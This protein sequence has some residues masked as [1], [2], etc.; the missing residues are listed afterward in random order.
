MM[1]FPADALTPSCQSTRPTMP[2]RWWQ[3]RNG[4]K[5]SFF[6]LEKSPE[7]FAYALDSTRWLMKDWLDGWDSLQ[8]NN[9]MS[10]LGGLNP[11]H[12]QNFVETRFQVLPRFW[13]FQL[14]YFETKGVPLVFADFLLLRFLLDINEKSIVPMSE[15]CDRR[16]GRSFQATLRPFQFF[17]MT[18]P[19]KNIWVYLCVTPFWVHSLFWTWWILRGRFVEERKVMNLE[20]TAVFRERVS[21]MKVRGLPFFKLVNWGAGG[22]LILKWGKWQHNLFPKSLRDDL[23]V[24][25]FIGI[26]SIEKATNCNVVGHFP[27]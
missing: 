15:S 17:S 1:F 14:W 18:S 9:G 10:L 24:F 4:F 26:V 22:K 16:L 23:S 27:V 6:V 25:F 8:K 21:Q 13:T 2:K 11:T 12:A 3:K 7:K 20:K 19:Q 5:G